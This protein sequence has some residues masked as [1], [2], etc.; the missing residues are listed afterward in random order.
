MSGCMIKGFVQ[1]GT[2]RAVLVVLC[3]G[4]ISLGVLRATAFP[5]SKNV[6]ERDMTLVFLCANY[7]LADVNAE[8]S[9]GNDHVL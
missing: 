5:E 3:L 1:W 9:S 4:M 7:R 2:R 6:K 8:R